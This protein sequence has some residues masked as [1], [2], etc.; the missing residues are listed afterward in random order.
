[1]AIHVMT[2]KLGGGKTLCSVGRIRDRLRSGCRVATNLDLDLV[3]M[4]GPKVRDLNVIRIPDKPL[5]DDMHGIGI[6][7]TSY[8]ENLNG[9]L[10]LDECGTW[11]NSRNWSDKT[12]KP[13]NDW[14][15]HARKLGWDVILIIQDIKLLDSQAREALAEH[16]VF[17]KRMDRIQIPFIGSIYKAI[18]GYRL[19]G[20]RVHVAR[21]VYGIAPTDPVSD[22]WVYRGLDL[23]SCYD[24]KQLFMDQYPHHVHSL[25]TPWHLRGRFSVIKNKEFYMRLTKIYWKRFHGPAALFTGSVLGMVLGL[26]LIPIVQAMG[27][28]DEPKIAENTE[29]VEKSDQIVA[30]SDS[31]QIPLVESG[32]D[33]SDE[34]PSQRFASWGISGYM[35]SRKNVVYT[36]SDGSGN[37]YKMAE[38]EN[39]GYRLR[40]VS[41]CSVEFLPI[42]DS[43]TVAA[44]IF[45]ENCT[46]RDFTK[47]ALDLSTIPLISEYALKS[48][49]LPSY[50]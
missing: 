40:P 35:Q 24:T 28:I 14:F 6:G 1:M 42:G 12:R 33:L 11:F 15:L 34:T 13:V 43:G 32:D 18:T 4:F 25:L 8:D 20:P 50:Y 44:T 45:A 27:V 10:V 3:A 21:S 16:T 23:F 2:G 22:R 9:L 26:T 46:V 17:C 38:V 7:N 41:N 39:L 30:I 36:F 31:P 5:I 49:N 37:H 19:S 29:I 48:D 47:K